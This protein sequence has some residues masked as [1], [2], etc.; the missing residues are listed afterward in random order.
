MGC[1]ETAPSRMAGGAALFRIPGRLFPCRRVA[2]L[3]V[4]MVSGSPEPA[5]IVSLS[6]LKLSVKAR[7]E[8]GTPVLVE[9]VCRELRPGRGW[10]GLGAPTVEWTLGDVVSV[11]YTI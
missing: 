10:I 7:F 11:F 6:S 3:I 4:S 2:A 5:V 9:T 8:A 1:R